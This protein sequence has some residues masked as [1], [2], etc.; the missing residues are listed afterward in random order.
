MGIRL[1]DITTK[2][3]VGPRDPTAT[4]S[5]R[6]ITMGTTITAGAVGLVPATA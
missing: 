5:T 2:D 1:G 3:T 6:T 4:S